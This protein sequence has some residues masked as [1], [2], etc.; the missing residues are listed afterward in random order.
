MGAFR[1]VDFSKDAAGR[2][3]FSK[4]AADRQ[5]GFFEK[6]GFQSSGF[7]RPGAFNDSSFR[8]LAFWKLEFLKKLKSPKHELS[9]TRDGKRTEFSKIGAFR[10][11]DFSKDAAGWV[12]FSKDAAD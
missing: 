1:K 8:K 10:K 12:D 11:V 7:Q 2:V 9:R 5:P 3:D 6:F 4:D